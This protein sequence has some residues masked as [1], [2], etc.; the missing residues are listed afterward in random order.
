MAQVAGI[1]LDRTSIGVPKYVTIDLRKHA[2]IIPF[3]EGK[4]V[5]I[6]KP[7]KWTEKM[8]RSFDQAKNGE[9]YVRNLED[10]LNV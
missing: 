8:K 2:D 1:K 4:G 6:D 5:E 10:I 3:L 7:V 9:F